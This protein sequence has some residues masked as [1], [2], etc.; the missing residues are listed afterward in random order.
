M[1]QFLGT[2]GQRIL[3]HV[4]DAASRQSLL[5]FWIASLATRSAAGRNSFFAHAKNRDGN[6]HRRPAS[7]S[8]AAFRL[9]KMTARGLPPEKL[10]GMDHAAV[11][12]RLALGEREFD[13]HQ[14]AVAEH[15]HEHRELYAFVPPVCPRPHSPQSTCIAW[16]GSYWTSR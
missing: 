12:L 13:V 15:G 2:S 8:T 1:R 5:P 7:L 14:A 4:A 11:E 3:L 16:A 9:S 6:G 10:E